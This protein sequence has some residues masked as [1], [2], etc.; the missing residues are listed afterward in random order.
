[1]R[2]K[3]EIVPLTI[4]GMTAD[5]NGVGRIDGETV[6][7][8]RTAI[9]DRLQCRIVKALPTYAFGIIESLEEPSPDRAEPDCPV[10][11]A[12][13]GCAFRH[14]TYGAECAVKQQVVEDA[15]VRI[16]GL[17]PEFLPILGCDTPAGYRNKAQYPVGSQNGQ[18]VCGFYAKRSHR[19]V[20]YM[21]CPLQPSLFGE[22]LEAAMRLIQDMGIAPY[23]EQQGTGLLRHLYLR[24]GYHSGELMLCF[25]VTRPARKQLMP[26]C[27][28]LKAR[29][30]QLTSLCMNVNSARTNVIL[31]KHTE[32]LL[33]ADVI[34]DT[35]CGIR[36]Q[37]SP[38]AFYQV[39]TA[40]AER[41]YGIAAEFAQLTGNETLLDLYCGAG[42]IGLSMAHR[43]KKLIG[44]EIIPQAVENARK[45]A[46]ANGIANA[47]FF[48]G[49]AGKI[50]QRLAERGESP[51][52]IVV[53]PPRKGCDQA[54]INAVVQ[55]AP[56]RIV[57]ISCNPA[58]AARDCALLDKLGYRTNQVRA[59]DMFPRTGHVETVVLMSKKDT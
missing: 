43:V 30:P 7:V 19:I 57:M 47:D 54:T 27:E 22:L 10:Y 8:P 4:T 11:A 56:R 33:G 38:H 40:Q 50:A 25:V 16:G 36:L 53:D 1:M 26:L 51:D 6:F 46:A 29:F 39:N 21:N 31:G 48:C 24:Q 44:V 28:A 42:T 32:T 17:K 9:G 55:M 18:A 52:V 14:I 41:L 58:T 13:G 15:F 23:E 59:V 5:G 20:P 12:C 3:N 2:K 35:M 45:N 34:R 49:D 37:L